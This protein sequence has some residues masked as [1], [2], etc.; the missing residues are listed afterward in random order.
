MSRITLVIGSHFS[1]FGIE[2]AITYWTSPN[3]GCPFHFDYNNR[4]FGYTCFLVIAEFCINKK[5]LK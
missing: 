3:A 5:Q 4:R 1:S 2:S